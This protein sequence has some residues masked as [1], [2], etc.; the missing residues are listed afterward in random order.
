MKHKILLWLMLFF[1]PLALGT[2]CNTE[3]NLEN[4]KYE[5]KIL[6]LI[7]NNNNERYN[8]ILITSSTSRKGVPVGSSIGFYDRDFGEKM[9]E[10]DIVHFRV[11]MFK[12]WVGPETADHLWP[13]YVGVIDFKYNE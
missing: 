4:I 10:G 1:F 8:I 6:S 2:S 9:H 12:K 11:P 5:G 13:E 3:V 7:K